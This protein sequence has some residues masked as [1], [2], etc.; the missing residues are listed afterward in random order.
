MA[1]PA[2]LDTTALTNLVDAQGLIQARLAD[3][4]VVQAEA[5]LV[6]FHDWYN[7]A[8]VD[9]LSRQ[10]A[11]AVQAAQRV[12]AQTTDVFVTRVS[13]MVTGK[14]IRNA[15]PIDVTGLRAGT[16]ADRVYGRLA[17]NYRYLVS[18]HRTVEDAL[19]ATRARAVSMVNTDVQLA[20]RAQARK[21]FTAQ[22]ITDYRRILHPE[23]AR[24]G[25]C[26]L[27][28]V[29]SDRVYHTDKLLP[30]HDGCHCGVLP[31][32]EAWDPG[33]NLNAEDLKAL[34]AAAGGTGRDALKRV[35]V[36]EHHHGELGPILTHK[37]YDWRTPKDV[38]A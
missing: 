8:A 19:S 20:A 4:A 5:A 21:S 23:L 15:G 10:V 36:A 34:Y 25:S 7:P 38:A 24:H 17:K 6:A 2:R 33:V 11:D 22:R 13:G 28:I 32:T 29:A 31:V 26:G 1:T 14:L 16:V 27:C 12:V 35:V 30:I 9:A 37:Q 3:H 18:K